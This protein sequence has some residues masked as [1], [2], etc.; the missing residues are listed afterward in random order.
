MTDRLPL[1][2][3]IKGLTG[4]EVIAAQK[5]YGMDFEKLGGIRTLV[6]TVW[7]Y[8]NRAEKTS[9]QAIE[10]MTLSELESYF[11]EPDLDPESDQGKG[12]T[13]LNESPD[14]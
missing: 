7:A 12:S 6:A 10:G 11:P 9:W 13:L 8:E 1:E 3:S 5:R 14:D 4:F 2:Q